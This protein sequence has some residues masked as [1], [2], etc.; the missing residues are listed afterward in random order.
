MSNIAFFFSFV[1][2]DFHLA[3]RLVGQ[4]KNFYPTSLI[5]AIGDGAST[6]KHPGSACACWYRENL[7]RPDTI[8]EFTQQNFQFILDM[9]QSDPTID[10]VV[11]LDPDSFLK[12]KFNYL[13][14]EQWCG[15]LN[16]GDFTWGYSTWC[17][18]G[19]FLIKKIAIE[20]IVESQ[21][22]LDDRYREIQSL[23]EEQNR[24]YEDCRLGHVANSLGIFPTKWAEV[25]C[26]RLS[27]LDKRCRKKALVHPV[28]HIN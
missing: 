16:Q 4:L 17:K 14:D 1:D 11:K 18:G 13:P 20:K 24:V 28:K 23:E 8:G 19:G 26:G 3:E 21:L 7:K 22:L 27:K 5:M 9:L 15:E 2:S 6:S 10:S 12:R 25:S